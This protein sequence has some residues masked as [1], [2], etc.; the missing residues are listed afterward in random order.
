MKTDWSKNTR[1][2]KMVNNRN[3]AQK[4]IYNVLQRLRD[5]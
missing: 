2:S 1:Y 4:H 3:A 5:G